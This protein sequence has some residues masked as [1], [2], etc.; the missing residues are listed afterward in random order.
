MLNSLN[1]KIALIFISLGLLLL[2]ILLLQII[3]KMNKDQKEYTKRQIENVIYL[4]TQQLKLAQKA[5][6]EQGKIK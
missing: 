6:Q 4:T 5:L 3:P 1:K 2:S